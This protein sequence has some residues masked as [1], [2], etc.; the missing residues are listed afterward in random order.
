MS[1]DKILKIDSTIRDALEYYDKNQEKY[2]A[3]FNKIKYIKFIDNNNMIDDIIFYDQNNNILLESSYEILGVFLPQSQL[4]KW[5]WSIPT[6]N[7]KYTFISRQILTTYAF[8]LDNMEELALRADLT[9]SKIKITNKVQLD[10]HIALS[11]YLGKQP[12]IFKFYNK[13]DDDSKLTS[14]EKTNLNKT[15]KIKRTGDNM[16]TLNNTD[17]ISDDDVFKYI[18][19]EENNDENYMVTYLFI[20]DYKNIKI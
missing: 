8:N 19:D 6:I 13:F 15:P 5:A 3:F 12:L 17:S 16:K 18:S 20:L 14:E 4:W 1:D 7:K 11:S 9:N 2:N 10:I